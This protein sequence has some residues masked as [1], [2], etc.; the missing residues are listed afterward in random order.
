MGEVERGDGSYPR[1][2]PLSHVHL[3]LDPHVDPS[4]FGERKVPTAEVLA[5]ARNLAFECLEPLG[6][7]GYVSSPLVHLVRG[8]GGTCLG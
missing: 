8:F 1:G 2:H 6:K 4:R 3:A 5:N 7:L